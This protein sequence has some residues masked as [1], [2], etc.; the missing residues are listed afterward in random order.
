M[1]FVYRR[2]ILHEQL[3]LTVVREEALAQR[4]DVTLG[5]VST[6][7][8]IEIPLHNDQLAPPRSTPFI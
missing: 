7:E 2:V 6:V 8:S 1:S 5:A 4:I 3:R